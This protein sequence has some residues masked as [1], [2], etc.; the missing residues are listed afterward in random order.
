MQKAVG[1]NSR[2]I[3]SRS[4]FMYFFGSSSKTFQLLKINTVKPVNNDHPW[5][6]KKFFDKW[7]LLRVDRV[8]KCNKSSNWDLKMMVV[9]DRLSLLGVGR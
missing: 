5:N 3:F 7:S 8:D 9:I 2:M 6:P 1:S 4:L